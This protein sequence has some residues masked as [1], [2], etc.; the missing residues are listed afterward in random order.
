MKEDPVI[1]TILSRRCLVEAASSTALRRARV[2][3]RYTVEICRLCLQFILCPAVCTH[4]D[5]LSDIRSCL[6]D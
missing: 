3:A 4:L 6:T 2:C 1:V 5:T